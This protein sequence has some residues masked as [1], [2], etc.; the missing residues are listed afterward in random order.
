[1]VPYQFLIRFAA[2]VSLFLVPLLAPASEVLLNALKQ[3][4]GRWSGT[5]NL[6]S[7]A[8]GYSETFA[9]TQQYWMSGKQLRGVAVFER[10]NGQESAQSVTYIF[11]DKLVSEI[12]SGAKI[13]KYLGVLNEGGVLWLPEDFK[14]ANDYQITETIVVEDGKRVLKT[15]GFDT[16]VYQEGLAYITIRGNL[17]FQE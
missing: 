15:D 14:R 8:T 3:F 10:E 5:F 11:E 4:E 6:H 9:V 17:I 7:A 12:S 2:V 16:F 1:V 13:E